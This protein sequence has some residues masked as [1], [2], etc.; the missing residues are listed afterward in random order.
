[1]E[2]PDS[3][4][5]CPNHHQQ[6]SGE[7]GG[8]KGSLKS[9]VGLTQAGVDVAEDSGWL[10]SDGVDFGHCL[11]QNALLAQGGLDGLCLCQEAY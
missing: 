9:S 4:L 5:H 3:P 8:G 7:S 1:M 10:N 2:D 6:D 11:H